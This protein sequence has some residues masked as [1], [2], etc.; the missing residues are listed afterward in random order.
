MAI[1]KPQVSGPSNPILPSSRFHR[2]EMECLVAP[3]PLKPRAAATGDL[4]IQM[5]SEARASALRGPAKVVYAHWAP[6]PGRATAWSLE[7]ICRAWAA[8]L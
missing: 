7:L 8:Q 3:P 5:D 4:A 1:S 6:H 2:Q